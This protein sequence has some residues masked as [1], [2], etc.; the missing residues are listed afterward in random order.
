MIW[1]S[2]G[3]NAAL[4]G[5]I[6]LSFAGV[7]SIAAIGP[8]EAPSQ[9]E[10]KSCLNAV[11]PVHHLVILDNALDGSFQCLGLS[12]EHGTVIALWLETHHISASGRQAGV[13]TEEFPVAV[14]ESSHGAVLD[15]VPGH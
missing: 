15:G 8:A 1:S 12:V 13:S 6:G 5:V 4:A 2:S 3:R 11:G 7:P 10:Q 14:V 9:S